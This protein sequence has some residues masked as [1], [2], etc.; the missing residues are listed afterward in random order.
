MSGLIKQSIAEQKQVRTSPD[1]RVT[2]PG[3][4]GRPCAR[5]RGGVRRLGHATSPRVD[6]RRPASRCYSQRRVAAK[7]V[8]KRPAH[9]Q[10]AGV[11]SRAA[12][13]AA[14]KEPP[15]SPNNNTPPRPPLTAVTPTPAATAPLSVA[16]PA[17]A[18]VPAP[19]L[20][21]L[22]AGL[23][24]PVTFWLWVDDASQRALQQLVRI[25]LVSHACWHT[26]TGRHGRGAKLLSSA[27][28]RPASE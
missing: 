1:C 19:S 25:Q 28:D 26:M 13:Q 4:A 27:A 14:V 16:A 9:R 11:A 5:K 3:G 20:L 23:L 15:P 2:A 17:A 24:L 21:V 10:P 6:P 8:T 7:H 22:V 18:A 12:R